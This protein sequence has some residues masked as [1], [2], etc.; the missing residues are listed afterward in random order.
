[1][2]APIRDPRSAVLNLPKPP[3]ARSA[4]SHQAWRSVASRL[5]TFDIRR[6]DRPLA[7][8][9]VRVWGSMHPPVIRVPVPE[10][11]Y[12]C[13]VYSAADLES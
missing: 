2:A 11:V 5:R 3:H 1:M 6:S 13:R 7:D 10:C 9:P 8:A 12:G 4:N